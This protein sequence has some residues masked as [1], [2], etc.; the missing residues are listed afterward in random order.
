MDFIEMV[1]IITSSPTSF[2]RQVWRTLAQMM[3]GGHWID[4]AGLTWAFCMLV[5]KIMSYSLAVFLAKSSLSLSPTERIYSYAGVA[6]SDFRNK[7]IIERKRM[8]FSNLSFHDLAI[9]K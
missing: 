8:L 2:S 4:L 6:I 1:I 9:V 3:T 7:T 5:V